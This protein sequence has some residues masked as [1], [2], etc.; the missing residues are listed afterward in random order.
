M[1]LAAH[2]QWLGQLAA[3]AVVALFN[4]GFWRNSLVDGKKEDEKSGLFKR[5]V[6]FLSLN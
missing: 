3:L 5:T 2:E 1:P 4:S 6:I